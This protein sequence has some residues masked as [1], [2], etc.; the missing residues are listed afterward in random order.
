MADNIAY[1]KFRKALLDSL[2]KDP[3]RFW[4]VCNT[5]DVQGLRSFQD[6][7]IKKCLPKYLHQTLKIW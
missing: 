4:G 3:K 2:I 1:A 7:G 6:L 5:N